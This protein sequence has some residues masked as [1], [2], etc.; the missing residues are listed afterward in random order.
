MVPVRIA[1]KRSKED[2]QVSPGR[3]AESRVVLLTTVLLAVVGALTLLLVVGL[4]QLPSA[5]AQNAGQSEDQNSSVT[6]GRP[7]VAMSPISGDASSPRRHFRLAD[8]AELSVS[9]AEDI[10][11]IV[12]KSMRVG[13]GRS[14][15]KTARDYLDWRRFN[16]APYLSSTH[17]NHYINN[18]ANGQATAYGRFE[19][20]GRLPVGSIIAKDSFS[21]TETGGLLIGPLFIMEKMP[22][23]F[24]FVTGDWRYIVVQPDGAVLGETNGPGA[25][26]VE[27]CIACH[28]AVEHQDHLYFIPKNRRV[29]FRD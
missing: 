8:P 21:V 22:K 12:S 27:Y 3:L 26:R 20:A 10:Y 16:D 7:E 15:L 4:G 25:K 6:T 19:E 28:L 9:R 18:Y 17:G 11:R 29:E 2:C 1:T 14:S 5:W 23:G 24:N 13:Y